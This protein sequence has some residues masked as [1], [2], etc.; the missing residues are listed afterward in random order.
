MVGDFT[1]SR[2]TP[3]QQARL[4]ELLKALQRQLGIPASRVVL[5][6]DDA[7][8]AGTGSAFPAGPFRSQLLP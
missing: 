8:A 6:T 5:R 2:P 1:R 3:T 4:V 7:S